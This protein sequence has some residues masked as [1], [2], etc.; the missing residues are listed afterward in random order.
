MP[1][2][3][4]DSS[5][6][7]EIAKLLLSDKVNVDAANSGLSLPVRSVNRMGCNQ[8]REKTRLENF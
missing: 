1:A 7:E 6:G 8:L 5:N 3:R 2:E 4:N